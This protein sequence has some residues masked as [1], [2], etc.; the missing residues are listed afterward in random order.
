MHEEKEIKEVKAGGSSEI[1]NDLEEAA[2]EFANQDCVT[3]ISRKKGF[4]A[5]AKWQEEH[6]PLPEDTVMFNKGVEEGKR[7]LMEEA[8]EG[9]VCYGSKGAYIETDFLGEYDTDVY[10]NP[11]DKVRVIVLPKED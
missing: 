4:I 2:N 1:P 8:V 10:G 3:F 11:G 7:L 6:A 9:V 5:G